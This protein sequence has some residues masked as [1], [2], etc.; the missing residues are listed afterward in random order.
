MDGLPATFTP[1]AAAPPP[2]PPSRRTLARRNSRRK[3]QKHYNYVV[4]GAGVAAYSAIQALESG[5]PEGTVLIVSDEKTLPRL[6]D[7]DDLQHDFRIS[8]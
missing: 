4:V 5:D 6:A 8:R 7:E 3:Q 1:L 2:P